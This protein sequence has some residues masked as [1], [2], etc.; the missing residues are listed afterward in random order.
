MTI[1]RERKANAPSPIQK[2]SSSFVKVFWLNL[3][4]VRTRLKQSAERL[5]ENHPEIEEVWVFGSL[6]RGDAVPGSDADVLIVLSDS[7]LPFLDRSAHYQPDFCGVGVDVFA[8]TRAEIAQMQHDGRAFLRRAQAEG[9][10]L[11]RSG[12]HHTSVQHDDALELT[13]NGIPVTLRPF[14]Q[15]YIFEDLH[16][17]RSAFI[18]IE[19]TLAWG[20]LPGLRWL[21]ARYGAARLAEWVQRAGWYCLPRRRF[22]YWLCFFEISDY[23]HGELIWQH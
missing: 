4:Q 10:C 13:P 17:E 16:P 12:A 22:K 5:A 11:F 7:A 6:A 19:R 20:D 1:T 3:N 8:Y 9:V 15:E 18:V 14:F 2:T 21:F 23:R